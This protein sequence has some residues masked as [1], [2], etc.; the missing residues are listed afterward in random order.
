MEYYYLVQANYVCTFLSTEFTFLVYRV[1]LIRNGCSRVSQKWLGT[2]II[3]NISQRIMF[4]SI[5]RRTITVHSVL[6]NA[7]G[8]ICFRDTNRYNYN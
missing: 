4:R 3:T 7:P 2:A 1:G 5:N 6:T 8:I